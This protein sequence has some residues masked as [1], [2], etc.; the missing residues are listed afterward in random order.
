[1]TAIRALKNQYLG[2]N[3]HLHSL[4]QNEGEWN[5]FHGLHIADLTTTLQAQ[6]LPMGYEANLKR[7]LQ[8]RRHSQ[9]HYH[10][11]WIYKTNPSKKGI[12][13]AWIE[14]I[15]DSNKSNKR[16]LVRYHEKRFQLLKMGVVLVEIDYLYQP[17]TKI[18]N[19]FAKGRDIPPYR[20]NVHD[21]RPDLA[22]GKLLTYQF[23]ID[24][25]LPKLI[26]PL[27]WAD[28]LLFDFGIP[29]KKTF[30]EMFYGNEL[31]YSF[32]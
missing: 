23:N 29:Y 16:N 20:I 1:M 27:H 17:P 31:D 22:R 14:L 12:P 18:D 25:P 6:L 9:K 5:S 15:T 21:P 28:Q 24:D 11:V 8:I 19:F 4:L 2:I 13:I 32:P 10:A 26:I 30:E 3:A 7:S